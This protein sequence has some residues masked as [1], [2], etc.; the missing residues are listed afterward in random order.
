MEDKKIQWHPGFVEAMDMEFK[1]D[2]GK[3]DFENEH[4]LNTK[5][6]KNTCGLRL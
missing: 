1:E 3:L 4:N 6:R 5:H 2:R